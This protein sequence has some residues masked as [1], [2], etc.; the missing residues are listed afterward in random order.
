RITRELASVYSQHV[1]VVLPSLR[2]GSHGPQIAGLIDRRG[3]SVDAVEARIPDDDAL[4]RAGIEHA[5]ALA[6]TSGDDQLN[7][8]IALRA[9]RLNPRVRLVIRMF[10][11]NLGQYLEDLL[12]RAARLSGAGRPDGREAPG[13]P[14]EAT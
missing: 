14:E 1:T 12:D 8:Y 2:G 5:S 10:N 7:I 3:L 6:L 11:R 13:E 4:L 9:R